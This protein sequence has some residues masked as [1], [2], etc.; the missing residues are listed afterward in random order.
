MDRDAAFEELYRRFY[1]RLVGYLIHSFHFSRDEAADVAQ[2]AF[3]RVFE[4]LDQYRAE[5][6]WAF[7]QSV[8]KNVALNKFRARY[9]LKRS[10]SIEAIDTEAVRLSS[11]IP[12]KISTPVQRAEAHEMKERLTAAIDALP[13]ATRS[14]LILRLEDLSYAEIATRLDITVSAVKSRVRAARV[15]LREQ[16]ALDPFAPTLVDDSLENVVLF[17]TQ[18]NDD[19]APPTDASFDQSAQELIEKLEAVTARNRQLS[20][21]IDAYAGMLSRHE[22]TIATIAAG[23]VAAV[24]SS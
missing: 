14:V 1:P 6:K 11:S 19:V 9:A 16:L 21:Q 8:A 12:D 24:R 20:R 7:V 13:P 23:S 2:D 4:S 17:P 10:S 3:L 15:R 5:A 18:Y 22:K